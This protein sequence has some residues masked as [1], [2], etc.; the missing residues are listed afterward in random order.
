MNVSS[1]KISRTLEILI[2]KYVTFE[3]TF[4]IKNNLELIKK[5]D[6]V[7]IPDRATLVSFNIANFYTNIPVS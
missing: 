4:S 3:N 7:T 1:Y 5:I 2:R 6:N